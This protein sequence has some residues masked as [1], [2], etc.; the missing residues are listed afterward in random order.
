[1]KEGVGERLDT[2]T[3]R[4]FTYYTEDDFSRHLGN[5]GFS[6][7]RFEERITEEETWLIFYVKKE[8]QSL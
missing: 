2:Q 6:V 4:L 5:T 7:L 8:P 3:G 1:M